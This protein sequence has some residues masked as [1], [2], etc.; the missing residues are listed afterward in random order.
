VGSYQR[1][2]EMALWAVVL[3]KGDLSIVS[4]NTSSGGGG[5]T[6]GRQSAEERDARAM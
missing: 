4:C 6:Q 2:V 3:R 1:Q 5:A